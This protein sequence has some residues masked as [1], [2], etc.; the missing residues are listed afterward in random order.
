MQARNVA[1]SKGID[2]S[3][4][5]TVENWSAVRNSGISFVIIKS[6][7]GS[8]GIDQSL[9]SHLSG[10]KSVG[11]KVGVY[12]FCRAKDTQSAIQEA[13]F[14]VSTINSIGGFGILD[15]APVLDLE[16]PEGASRANVVSVCRTW[17]ERVKQLSGV[18]PMLY[19]FPSFADEFLDNTLA[20]I[21]LWLAD[22]SHDTPPNHAGWSQ[23]TFLQYSEKGRVTGIDG[24]VDMDEFDGDIQNYRIQM[25]DE[26]NMP[27]K[28]DDWAWAELE[29][30]FGDAYNDGTI[31]SW[32][33]IQK[34]KDRQLTLTDC[35]LLKVLIDERR[36]T[37]A[38][39]Q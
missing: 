27:M 28:I 13:D 26:D 3:H 34:T 15:I 31:T 24:Y 1:N 30:T 22:Y 23:W 16:T 39:G 12:H 32:A 33:W 11:I 8:S 6:T 4:Y 36:R 35:I 20:D 38:L 18:Q 17:I 19:S 25:E 2:I 7:E 10:A 37:K 14:F 9:Q 29:K 21:P 5:Q